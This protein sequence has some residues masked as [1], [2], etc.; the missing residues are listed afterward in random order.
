MTDDKLTSEE[1]AEVRDMVQRVT[2]AT[3][4]VMQVTTPRTRDDLIANVTALKFLADT[5]YE[6]LDPDS[7]AMVDAM[8]EAQKLVLCPL[9]DGPRRRREESSH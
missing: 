9:L 4:R 7:R 8:V 1:Q 5:A 3:K 6:I 2:E